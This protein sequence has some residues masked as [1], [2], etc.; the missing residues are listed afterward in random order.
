VHVT[1][2]ARV[3]V[4]TPHTVAAPGGPQLV[5]EDR[6]ADHWGAS[7]VE[8]KL[9]ESVAEVGRNRVTPTGRTPEVDRLVGPTAPWMTDVGV[10][11]GPRE[12]AEGNLNHA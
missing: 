12:A 5:L 2:A 1:F 8:Q 10:G 4:G 6:V 3:V 7:E 11:R 9:M